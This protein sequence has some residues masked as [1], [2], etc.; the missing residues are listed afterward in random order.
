M[1]YASVAHLSVEGA[2][3]E[4]GPEELSFREPVHGPLAAAADERE[5]QTRVEEQ[6][7]ALRRGG[8]G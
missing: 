7:Q 2:D 6:H 5:Q 4:A 3:L 8:R 1:R